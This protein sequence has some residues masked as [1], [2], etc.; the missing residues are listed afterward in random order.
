MR[1]ATADPGLRRGLNDWVAVAAAELRSARRLARTWV[2]V[3]LGFGV[4]GMTYGY[5]SY[6]HSS[7][8][9]GFLSAG[10]LLPRF[11]TAYF[12]RELYT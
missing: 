6:L 7:V 4:M 10:D 2:F 5:Y 8:S 3:G 11:A 9:T 12:K 1:L